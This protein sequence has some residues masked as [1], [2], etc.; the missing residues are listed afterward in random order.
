MSLEKEVSDIF[1]RFNEVTRNKAHYRPSV[2]NKFTFGKLEKKYNINRP[3]I[4]KWERKEK[5]ATD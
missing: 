4:K 1:K 3:S 2:N 5:E